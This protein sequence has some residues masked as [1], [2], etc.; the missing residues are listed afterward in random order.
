AHT[1]GIRN[2]G[3]LTMKA[4]AVTDTKTLDEDG[5]GIYSNGSLT[6]IR[7]VVRHNATGGSYNS[8][9]GIYNAGRAV[10]VDS[11][12]NENGGYLGAGIRSNGTM[13]LT[14]TLVSGNN[15]DIGGGILNRRTMLLK[16]TTLAHHPAAHHSQIRSGP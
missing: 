10:L 3:V 11:S 5:A 1:M 7:T 13:T 15:G 4:S 6:L 14:R 12:V 9:G 8:G 2:N 16:R